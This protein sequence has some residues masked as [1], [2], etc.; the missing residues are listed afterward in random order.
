[1]GEVIKYEHWGKQVFVD[2]DLKGGHRDYCLCFRCE[3]FRPESREENC[4]LANLNYAMDVLTNLVTPVWECPEF[5][6][7]QG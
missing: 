2:E 5:T 6:K 4:H 1:M 3:R 7:R